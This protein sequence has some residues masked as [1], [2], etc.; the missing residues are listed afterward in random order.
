MK[1]YK[2]KSIG[3]E[4]SGIDN[5]AYIYCKILLINGIFLTFWYWQGKIKGIYI[6]FD[7][8]WKKKQEMFRQTDIFVALLLVSSI[9][10]KFNLFS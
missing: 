1:N 6:K 4:Y 5:F 8:D 3:L 10:S 7:V 2:K 9:F